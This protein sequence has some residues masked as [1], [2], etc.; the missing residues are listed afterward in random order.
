MA[1]DLFE[2]SIDEAGP[3]RMLVLAAVASI[4][5]CVAN[6]MF[7][8]PK[9]FAAAST[10]LWL[11][12]GLLAV[13]DNNRVAASISLGKWVPALGV[14]LAVAGLAAGS[15]LIRFDGDL[16]RARLAAARLDW[17]GVLDATDRLNSFAG[18]DEQA[19]LLQA[20]AYE[21]TGRHDK[22]VEAYRKGLLIHPHAT[23]LWLGLGVALRMAGQVDSAQQSFERALLYDPQDGR[24]LNNLGTLI[25]SQGDLERATVYLERALAAESTPADVYGNLSTV[26]RRAGA[27]DKAIESA[28]RGL[29][30]DP[31]GDL[32]NALGNAYAARGDYEEAVR[33][34]AGGLVTSPDH[35][36]LL[37]NLARSYD[38][39]S[40][41][42]E[43]IRTYQKVLTR[44]RGSF[45]ERRKFIEKRI[46]LLEKG[47]G[48]QQ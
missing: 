11:G 28:R 43:A 48:S 7:S 25:A 12:M 33:T 41:V 45:P 37:F 38:S 31:S 44:I 9:E 2:A 18:V 30:I 24:V 21:G 27:L 39:L 46:V 29:V 40:R 3:D 16:V 8:F 35:V 47:P 15:L 36:Q 19:H 23:S 5:G 10:P 13:L 17:Q 42:G 4:V 32:A 6:S 22:A 20:R 1:D 34:Y 14:C 26:Y